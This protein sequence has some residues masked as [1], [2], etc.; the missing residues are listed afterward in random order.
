MAVEPVSRPAAQAAGRYAWA[1]PGTEDLGG[2]VYRI[3]LPLPGDAL[4]A[5]NVYALTDSEGV[6][7][8]DAGMALAAAREQLAAALRQLG[9]GVGDVRNFF[10]THVHRDHY[11][12]AVELR[13]AH[14]G[15]IA[16][17]EGER[18]NLRA[19][20][21]VA[22]GRRERATVAGLHRQGASELAGRLGGQDAP[23][24]PPDLTQWEDP[25]HWLADGTDLDVRS[26]TLRVVHTPGHTRGHVVFHDA[27]S[28]A[29]FAGDH[30]LPHITP[31]IGFEPAGNRMALRDYLGSL[32]LML[33]LPDSR[34]LPAH[35][36]VA[37]S[38][39]RRVTELL[40][41][42]ETRLTQT[43]EAVSAGMSTAYEVAKAIPWTRRRRN[44]ADLE[45]ISQLLATNETAAHLE[46]LLLRGEVTRQAA[47]DGTE[48]YSPAEPGPADSDLAA[49]GPTA[50]EPEPTE[51]E[52]TEP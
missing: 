43:R 27:A 19:V 11:T 41:H 2:G 34:L 29:L 36:P 33:A 51:P 6:D 18:A 4:T 40:A 21:A 14:R 22:S 46:V 10:I 49:A 50:T 47:P 25:D 35:G 42:H 12:L 32:E 24:G 3:P 5:V 37:D 38:T 13:R 16:L 30:V 28:A 20:H 17:G 39:H 52:P 15:A 48:L 44:F 1:E 26:R 7:L 23:N 31:S 9:Y 45:L 8:V